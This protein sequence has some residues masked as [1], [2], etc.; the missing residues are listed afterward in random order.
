MIMRDLILLILMDI[1]PCELHTYAVVCMYKVLFCG[2]LE[3][4]C[5]V[6]I[7]MYCIKCDFFCNGVLF[8][9]LCSVFQF[10]ENP[11]HCHFH[12]CLNNFIW[13]V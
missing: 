10:C 9:F 12:D 7:Y 11:K 8:V 13:L 3:H 6:C 4:L 1:Y 2:T 5:G